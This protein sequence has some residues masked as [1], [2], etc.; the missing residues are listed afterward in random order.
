MK[1]IVVGTAIS[2][3]AG[4]KKGSLRIGTLPDGSPMEIPV[5]I[6][7]GS[8]PGPVLWL[9]GCVH[10][11]EY[12]G[13][14]IIHEML[15]RL[16]PAALTG[17]VVALPALNITAFQKG[18]RMS[19]FEGFAGGDL[20]RNFPGD[21]TG[22]LTQQM[23]YAIYKP[24][25]RH[26]THLVDFHTA[27]TEDVAWALYADVGGKTGKESEKMARAFGYRSTLPAPPTI[28]GGSALMT[29][30]KDGIPAMIVECGGKGPAFTQEAMRDGADRLENILRALG[31]VKGAVVDHGKLN[32]FSN[33]AWVHATKGGLF[34]RSVRCGDRIEPGSVLGQY[35]DLHGRPNGEA[36]APKGGIVL[37]IHPGPMIGSG[38]TLIHIGLD[39]REV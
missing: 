19:P 17:T 35:Y 29:A 16:R 33:F 3:A 1:E 10:G 23:A 12:C 20:N 30:A 21:A 11:N 31:M 2:K 14:F 13:T 5:V 22:T 37:A 26:A 6:V 34:Q 9:H 36:L 8:K 15:S 24:L 4:R 18:Q 7:R 38:E 27:M 25:K 28:L 39:P 32:Y